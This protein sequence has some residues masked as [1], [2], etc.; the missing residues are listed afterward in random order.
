MASRRP[1]ESL[2]NNEKSLPVN[3]VSPFV[4]NPTV[5]NETNAIN[6][7]DENVSLASNSYHYAIIVNNI[8]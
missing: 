4:P 1:L 7:T 2:N 6:S 8:L 5:H 3:T